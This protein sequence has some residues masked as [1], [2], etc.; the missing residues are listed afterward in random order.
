MTDLKLMRS[1][2]Y[3][4][5]QSAPGLAV[6]NGVLVTLRL[7]GR[8]HQVEVAA[9]PKT[10]ET[11]LT[12]RALEKLAPRHAEARAALE[13]LKKTARPDARAPG[14]RLPGGTLRAL[15]PVGMI[16]GAIVDALECGKERRPEEVEAIARAIKRGQM[17]PE[18]LG[19]CQDLVNQVQRART[20]E[21]LGIPDA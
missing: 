5:A 20:K 19:L 9:T 15:G 4:S 10:S 7:A 17:V 6:G 18:Q 3:Q 13:E 21:L 14:A 12:K 11:E 1:L 16:A 2:P 8:E